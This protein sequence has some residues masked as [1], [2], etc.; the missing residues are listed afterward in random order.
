MLKVMS[1]LGSLQRWPLGWKQAGGSS[2][3]T[4]SRKDLRALESSNGCNFGSHFERWGWVACVVLPL[5][6]VAGSMAG[7]WRPF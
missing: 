3:A 2:E 7:P 6:V 5:I 4:F 1:R